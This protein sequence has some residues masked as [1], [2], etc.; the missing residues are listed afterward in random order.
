[1]T[2]SHSI[3]HAL[4]HPLPEGNDARLVLFA[5]RRLGAHGL[6]DAC[7]AHGFLT[8][9]GQSFRRPLVLMRAFML[10]V[11]RTATQ[12]IAIAPCCCAR[13]TASEAALLEILARAGSSPESARLLLV[14]QLGTRA[15]DSVL[16]SAAAVGAAFADAGRPIGG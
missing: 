14:D 4:P 16:A 15:V 13:A 2:T 12:P 9:F 1:M 11:A 10:D 8:A 6:N 5:I 7:A 3:V